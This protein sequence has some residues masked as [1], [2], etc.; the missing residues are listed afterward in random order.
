MRPCARGIQCSN[1]V[2]N[3]TGN[4]SPRYTYTAFCISDEHAIGNMLHECPRIYAELSAYLPRSQV[5]GGAPVSGSRLPPLPL[6]LEVL[7]VQEDLS[8][9]LRDFAARVRGSS[10][11][12]DRRP[13]IAVAQDSG[14]L[15]THLGALLAL[16]DG[17]TGAEV[18]LWLLH[19]RTRAH[20]IMGTHTTFERKSV[21]CPVC[22]TKALVRTYGNDHVECRS[23]GKRIAE[24]EYN[25]WEHSH[26]YGVTQG[27]R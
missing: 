6:R 3:S 18:G 4:Y 25:A 8:V 24:N 12:L 10:V 19:W 13:L 23:C 26:V 5:A 7:T 27:D 21:P 9:T 15:R 14:Y 11:P 22:D 1:P 17:V 20:R 16:D 2:V